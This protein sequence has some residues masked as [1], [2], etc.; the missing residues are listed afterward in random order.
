[1][2]RVGRVMTAELKSKIA[3]LAARVT[4]LEGA[5]R[6][7]ATRGKVVS[8]AFAQNRALVQI[9][10]LAGET[11]DRV[12]LLQPGGVSAYPEPDA[13]V[14]VL[15]LLGIRDLAV[16]ICGDKLGSGVPNL[17]AGERGIGDGSAY[18]AVRGNRLHLYA[19]GRD[20]VVESAANV[21]ISASANVSISA[22]GTVSVSGTEIDLTGVVKANGQMVMTTP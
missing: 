20:V 3:A 4:A 22:S 8:T 1:M 18:F 9:Q 15:Q 11:L 10:T 12:E 19:A 2:E 16:A 13:E 14:V 5:A 6:S 17:A 7:A 21:T